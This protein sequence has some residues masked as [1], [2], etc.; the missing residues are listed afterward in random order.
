MTYESRRAAMRRDSRVMLNLAFYGLLLFVFL[1]C[2][3]NGWL[4]SALA[5]WGE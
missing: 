5:A 2:W 1:V 4:G 3:W